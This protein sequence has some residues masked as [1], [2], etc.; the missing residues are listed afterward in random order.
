MSHRL[1][2]RLTQ[3][4][5]EGVAPGLRPDA[6]T[7]V[8]IGYE[9]DRPVRVDTVVLS[10]QHEDTLDH[11]RDLPGLVGE[12]V[13]DHVLGGFAAGMD[14]DI[15]DV[16]TLINPS[17]AFVLGGPMGDAGLTGRKIIV[18]TYGGMARHGGG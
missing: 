12:H 15:S 7:Q 10:T 9:G 1:T 17:G 16:T 6:K 13:I 18:D 11:E 5:K 14:L 4:R 2:Q 8:T 3:V